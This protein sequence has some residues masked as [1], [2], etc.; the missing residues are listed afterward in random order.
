M[1]KRK[2]IFWLYIVLLHLL[3]AV[4][5]QRMGLIPRLIAK[6]SGTIVE[7]TSLY[8]AL[9]PY[10]RRMDGSV[11]DG[12]IVF[13]GDS[14]VHALVTSA[15]ADKTANYG[16][17]GDTVAGL[18]D[19]L[20]IYESLA[21]ARAIV[22]SIGVNDLWWRS[23]D[24]IEL[25]YRQLFSQ[26]PQQVPVLANAIF[27]VEEKFDFPDGTNDRI[28]ALN[29]AVAAVANEHDNVTFLDYS[30]EFTSDSAQL[31]PSLHIGDGLHLNTRGYQLWIDILR[32][33]LRTVTSLQ[34]E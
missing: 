18:I 11:P 25:L 3:I 4:L 19:R 24:E 14:M 32:D 23:N 26:L 9:L 28:N 10:H 7:N 6:F 22:V 12:A 8:N 30:A 31:D 27:P 34:V 21:G 5:V 33:N 2:V 1:S 20:S 13:I 17:G 29:S 15:I 16:I